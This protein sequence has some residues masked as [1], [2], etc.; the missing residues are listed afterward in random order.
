MQS[1]VLQVF[2]KASLMISYDPRINGTETC[3]ASAVAVQL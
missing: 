2:L 1:T 3:N